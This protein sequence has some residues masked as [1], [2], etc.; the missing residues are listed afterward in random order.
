VL[1]WILL[2]IAVFLVVLFV[3]LFVCKNKKQETDYRAWFIIGLTCVAV[4]LPL[5]NYLVF[6]IG[7]VFATLGVLNREKWK[8]NDFDWKKDTLKILLLTLGMVLLVAAI[9]LVYWLKHLGML[10]PWLLR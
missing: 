1:P 7:I 4:G 2:A 9:A 8:R 3:Y 6:A 5:E 10:P